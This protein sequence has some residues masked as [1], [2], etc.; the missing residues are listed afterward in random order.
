MF[1][2]QAI[3]F[4]VSAFLGLA[5]L[6]ADLVASGLGGRPLYEALLEA[7]LRRSPPPGAGRGG[8]CEPR[9][10]YVGVQRGSALEGRTLRG[11]DLPAGC[12]VVLIER[13]GREVLPEPDL[14]LF[15]GD[16]LTVLVPAEDPSKA[17]EVVSRATGI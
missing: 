3:H 8:A 16:H 10:V 5:C 2:G 17:M 13:G 4:G 11:A 1:V 6:T 14:T 12:L 15:P 7:D 9:S